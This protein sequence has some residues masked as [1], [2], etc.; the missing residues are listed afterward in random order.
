MGCYI[1]H[2]LFSTTSPPTYLLA[3]LHAVDL[4]AS[5]LC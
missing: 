2:F 5:Y 1:L 3:D 4:L